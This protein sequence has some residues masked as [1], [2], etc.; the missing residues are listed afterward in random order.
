MIIV[1]DCSPLSNL[2]LIDELD[3]LR[4]LFSEVIVPPKVHHEILALSKL[5]INLSEYT[6]SSWIRIEK[7]VDPSEVSK[8][9]SVVDQGEAEAIVLAT[10]LHA[11]YLLI[12]E[13]IGTA[14]ANKRNLRTV[15]LMGV[16]V[17]AK[18]QH[19]ISEVKP[20]LLR[21]NQE[22]FWL[23]EKLIQQILNSVS[24]S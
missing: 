22:G 8:L 20:Y 5:G 14:E 18:Q 9:L 2:I 19:I 24:E 12:D 11:D 21:L 17:K 7:P 13:R 16:L 3:I 6:A 1:S 10:E 4:K 23:S 15:G